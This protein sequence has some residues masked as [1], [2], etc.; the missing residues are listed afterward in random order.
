[1]DAA[2][3]SVDVGRALQN[4]VQS[5]QVRAERRGVALQAEPFSRSVE[6]NPG[7]LSLLL[8]L[9][10][11]QA[12]E[13]SPAG[14]Q[15]RIASLPGGTGFHVDDAGTAVPSEARQA[16]LGLLQDPSSLGRPHGLH[17]G[18]AAALT[19]SLPASLTL[20]DAPEGGLRVSVIF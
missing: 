5:H 11:E 4:T 2:G 6:I 12:I 8:D 16:L 9:L 19:A 20:D 1:V 3:A 15:V 13:A 10:I 18:L 7:A 17:L 14:S